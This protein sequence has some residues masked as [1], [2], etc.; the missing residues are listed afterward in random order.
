MFIVTGPVCEQRGWQ[1]RECGA[2]SETVRVSETST[3]SISVIETPAIS[4]TR[5][6]VKFPVDV[7][8]HWSVARVECINATQTRQWS[9]RRQWTHSY[10]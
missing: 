5:R 7:T 3:V 2:S 1:T 8:S 6:V 9:F 4:V 10:E